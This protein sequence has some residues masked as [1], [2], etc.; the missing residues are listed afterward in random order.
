MRQQD[1]VE[2]MGLLLR[3][4]ALRQRF[5]EDRHAV[6]KELGVVSDDHDCLLS[7]DV[8]QLEAQAESL[9]RKRRA[10]VVR[11]LPNTWSCLGTQALCSFHEYVDDS[12]WPQGHR[13]HLLDALGFC[14]FLE[15]RKQVGYLKSEHQWV[16][17]LANDRIFSIRIVSDLM[18]R[19]NAWSGIQICF[20]LRGV[21]HRS[22]L[23][24]LSRGTPFAGQ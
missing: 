14:Q 20:R 16:W 17:F 5:A 6:I 11:F 7:L 3:D 24:L 21:A 8:E 19:E 23:R 22:A 2:A 12:H 4:R 9:I 10:E 13:R 18:I 1:A 15:E